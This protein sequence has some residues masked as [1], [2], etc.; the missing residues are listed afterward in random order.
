MKASGQ[1]GQKSKDSMAVTF[2]EEVEK[3]K[4]QVQSLFG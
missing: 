3:S 4:K 1:Y 2:I